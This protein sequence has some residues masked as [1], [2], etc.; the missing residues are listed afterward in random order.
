MVDFWNSLDDSRF[1]SQVL[2]EIFGIR[3]SVLGRNQVSVRK[4]FGLNEPGCCVDCNYCTLGVQYIGSSNGNRILD[5]AQEKALIFSREFPAYNIELVGYWYGV[6]SESS[7]FPRLLNLVRT[8]SSGNMIVGGDL[9]IINEKRVF[10]CLA[11]AGLSYLHNNLETSRRLYPIAIGKDKRRFDRKLET[12]RLAHDYGIPITSGVL[13]G[14][15]E[16]VDD[17]IEQVETLGSFPL[18]RIAVNFMDYS[19][20]RIAKRFRNVSGTLTPEHAFKVLVFLRYWIDIGTSLMVGSGVRRCLDYKRN[21]E[22]P[23]LEVVDTL[24]IGS[25]INLDESSGRT[26]ASVEEI[27]LKSTRELTERLGSLG[28]EIVRPINFV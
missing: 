11:E 5:D 26:N 8:L 7:G 6:N 14:L 9:G 4:T 16:E 21:L 2:D 19:D 22:V 20:P 23:L 13:I 18:S 12:L 17:L 15:G 25:F 10:E 1:Y 27:D 24:H 3:E 28:Y